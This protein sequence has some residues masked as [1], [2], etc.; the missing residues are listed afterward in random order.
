MPRYCMRWVGLKTDLSGYTMKP[1][2]RKSCNVSTILV[3]HS[4]CVLANS[5]ESSRKDVDACPWL[6]SVAKTGISNFV[7]FQGASPSANA[8]PIWKSIKLPKLAFPLEMKEFSVHFVI[9]YWAICIFQV[10]RSH[11]AVLCRKFQGCLKGVH[12]EMAI[13]DLFIQ[14]L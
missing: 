10:S 2:K 12:F 7:N 6:L 3:R 5:S 11:V 4:C 8:K 9:R 1:S 14:F 13:S